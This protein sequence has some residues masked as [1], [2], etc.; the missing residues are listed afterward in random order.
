MLASVIVKS[1]R[2][3]VCTQLNVTYEYVN[4][5]DPSC[6]IGARRVGQIAIIE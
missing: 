1:G 4:C 6:S 5:M 2:H 3:K